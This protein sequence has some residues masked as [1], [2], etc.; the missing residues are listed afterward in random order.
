MF[1]MIILL[2]VLIILCVSLLFVGF[3]SLSLPFSV[4]LFVFYFV[5]SSSCSLSLPP[6]PLSSYSVLTFPSSALFSLLSLVFFSSLFSSSLLPLSLILLFVPVVVSSFSFEPSFS[7]SF[8]VFSSLSPPLAFP[9]L[10]PLSSHPLFSLPLSSPFSFPIP[11]SSLHA[12]YSSFLFV[13]TASLVSFSSSSLSPGSLLFP[14]S[15]SGL[16]LFLHLLPLVLFLCLLR[17]FFPL[18]FSWHLPPLLPR[19]RPLSLPRFL[20][21]LLPLSFS[22]C[23]F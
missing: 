3:L 16:H 7:P 22:S 21:L 5:A 12:D 9:F 14:F 8:S 18:L 11:S 4:F 23:S 17:L 10:P 15:D 1:I 6:P 2:H 20:F 19:L 13:L